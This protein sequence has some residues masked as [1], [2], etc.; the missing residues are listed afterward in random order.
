MLTKLHLPGSTKL[1]KA[2]FPNGIESSKN[3]LKM[4]DGKRTY[5]ATI[6]NE[7][8]ARTRFA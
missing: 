6:R 3:R 5:N 2:S 7:V 8:I 1:L 4:N